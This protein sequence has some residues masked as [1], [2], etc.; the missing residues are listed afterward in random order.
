MRLEST[1]RV[2]VVEDDGTCCVIGGGLSASLAEEISRRLSASQV[3][4]AV[5]FEQEG[6]PSSSY[7]ALDASRTRAMRSGWERALAALGLISQ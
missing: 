6:C 5:R 4:R 1:Y 7:P 2:V 3:F